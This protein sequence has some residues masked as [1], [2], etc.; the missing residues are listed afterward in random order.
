M[1]QSTRVALED[2]RRQYPHHV[3][4]VL[5]LSAD[6]LQVESVQ[7]YHEGADHQE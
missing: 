5:G 2:P 1:L 6:R 4:T 3:K 7:S